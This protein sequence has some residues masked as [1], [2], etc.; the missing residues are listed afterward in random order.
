MGAAE[1]ISCEEVRASKQWD[2]LRRQLPARL[3]QWLDGLEAHFQEP[4]P[5]LAQ[6][7]ETV[8]NLRQELPSG[9]TETI[10]AQA[11]Q[12][13]YTSKQVHCPQCDGLLTARAPVPRTVETMGGPVQ[14]ERPYC[15]C[16]TCC[17]GLYPLDA[18]VGLT[19]G[20]TQ[21]DVQKAAAKLV[22]EVP[23]DEA[24][25][26]FGALTGLGLGRERLP[27]VTKQVAEGL[28]VLDVAPSRDEI[29]RRL[30]EAAGGDSAPSGRGAGHRW[31]V[32]THASRQRPRAPSGATREAGQARPV[33]RPVA[34]RPGLS[35][36]SPPWRA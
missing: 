27:T 14:R 31:G 30:A 7:T 17:C 25:T 13:E 28:R 33:A 6:G 34:R 18:V 4:T 26:L 3:E 21:L 29:E 32:R 15:Y 11:H 9:M 19:T 10:G 5:T 36:L 24:H 2:V 8:G 12:G 16:R 1:L 22:T 35:L 23:Y 20:R